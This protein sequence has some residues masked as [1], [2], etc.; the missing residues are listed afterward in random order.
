M[1]FR[2]G[3]FAWLVILAVL[4]LITTLS[5][6]LTYAQQTATPTPTVAASRSTS[7]TFTAIQSTRLRGGPGPTY[8]IVGTLNAGETATVTGQS[9]GSDRYIWWKLSTGSFVRS[10]LGTSNC[11]AVCGNQVCERA[12]TSTSCAQDCGGSTSTTSTTSTTTTTTTTNTASCVAKDCQSCYESISC[13]PACSECTC[14]RNAWGCP[15]CRCE[16]PSD[17]DTD[18][19]CKYES[20]EA[21]IAAF[22]CAGGP[23]TTK[24]CSLNENGCPVC[25]TSQ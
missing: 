21:C 24:E 8:E 4:F 13:Y 9:T 14:S 11:P 12:E 7:C 6:P 18:N 25:S 19:G 23:C 16:Y 5:I 17:N 10:D 3:V 15:V 2:T 1:K 20:C 22:P